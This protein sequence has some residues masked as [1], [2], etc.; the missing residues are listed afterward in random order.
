[1]SD[2]RWPAIRDLFLEALEQPDT[3]RDSFVAGRA[4]DDAALRQG[5]L[6][7]LAAHARP[8]PRLSRAADFDSSDGETDDPDSLIGGALGP[9]RVLR[10]IGEGGM[11][12]VFEAEQ[13]EPLRRRVAIKVVKRGM[14]TREVVRR[15][16]LER[17]ALALMN[18]SCIAKVFD[19]GMTA[20]GRPYFVM[21]LAEGLPITEYCDRERLT[22]R[23]RLRLLAT[24]CDAVQHAHHKGVVHRD[25]KPSNI[26]VI[27]EGGH[28]TPKVI[29]FGIAKAIGT[30]FDAQSL[31]TAVGT[32]IGTP[33][34]MSPEQ[35]ALGSS[36]IDA[37]TDIYSLAA[38]LYELCV[39]DP[40]FPA[41][42]LRGSD[43]L[44]A[45]Q[46]IREHDAER[47]SVR[48]RSFDAQRRAACARSRRSAPRDI[49]RELKEID[50]IV[51]RGLA[52]ERAERYQT[53][54][55]LAEE[56]ERYLAGLPLHAGPPSR[57][58]RARKFV[59]RHRFGVAAASSIAALLLAFAATMT[60]QSVRLE[61]ALVA[62]D[63]Q[64]A[65]A[66]GVSDFLVD[67]LRLPD[68]KEGNRA[69]MTIRE[70]LDSAARKIPAELADQPH[71]KAAVL[72][73]IGTV[74]REIG[75]YD[76][77][78]AQ[79]AAAVELM[80]AAHPRDEAELGRALNAL[81]ELAHDKGD[82]DAAERSYREALP[83]LREHPHR[84]TDASVVLNNLAVVAM[85]RDDANAAEAPAREALE[86][87]RRLFGPRGRDTGHSV[88]KL[89]RVLSQQGRW[90][91]AEP[92]LRE[93]MEIEAEHSS[94]DNVSRGTALAELNFVLRSKGDHRA[95]EEVSRQ[96]LALYR[97]NL[98]KHQYTAVT[99]LNL[100][101]ALT[102]LAKYEEARVTLDE[103]WTMLRDIFGTEHPHAARVLSARA[104]LE[105]ARGHYQSAEHELRGVIALSRR[106]FDPKH[107][108]VAANINLLGI[109]IRQLGRLDEGLKLQQEALAF[110]IDSLGADHSTLAPVY[111]DL[112]VTHIA[113]NDLAAA[114]VALREAMRIEA[115]ADLTSELHGALTLGVYGWLLHL[116]GQDEAALETLSAALAV[117]RPALG[118]QH[119]EVGQTLVRLG[120]IECA[121]G[122]HASGREHLALG[123]S[124]LQA[125]ALPAD[126]RL[127]QAGSALNQCNLTA[128]TQGISLPSSTR[129]PALASTRS[130]TRAQ[131]IGLSVVANSS[132]SLFQLS[133]RVR[134]LARRSSS[135]A[136]ISDAGTFSF[137]NWR[138]EYRLPPRSSHA[139]N[140]KL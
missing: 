39:G 123:A 131:R 119:P 78:Q 71:T 26:L 65:R 106:L 90:R 35:A 38:L 63:A 115:K 89:G 136:A 16:G 88:R 17:Q 91:E 120:Q 2:A 31:H 20:D 114:E 27:A 113:R 47:P 74:Y 92:L 8:D 29:D 51:M 40:P 50:W 140:Q 55:A 66:Q 103:A 6:R 109:A 138:F 70:V 32:L 22:L 116:Q 127:Q 52:K 54:A 4:G 64:R 72:T 48:L 18:H 104:E 130:Q 77:A 129:L 59:A 73:T 108:E 45:L 3:E 7:L 97:A 105:L 36:D 112:A 118:D 1:M 12:A 57:A 101:R 128:A 46:A 117:Q 79:L 61:R 19:A 82:L 5:V 15:F 86:M 13:T 42:T 98:G 96:A 100:G 111:R 110:R 34:Y 81:G 132:A 126:P 21:E 30:N 80:R 41:E 11:G 76:P 124:A 102:S 93:A 137:N 99:L 23:E 44:R 75:I 56:I 122:R 60:V 69:D 107:R 94:A 68:P 37:R 62:V 28:A 58:Y 87:R 25:L 33:A 49:E 24:L 133:N 53:P 139:H 85:D 121:N 135:S 67:M 83:L 125:A 134:P 84:L 43:Y 9:Y 95:S 10:Q 14:D